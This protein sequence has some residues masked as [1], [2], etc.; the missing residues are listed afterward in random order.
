MR[1]FRIILSLILVFA[2]LLSSIPSVYAGKYLDSY[3]YMDDIFKYDVGPFASSGENAVDENDALGQMITF[4]D[5]I[6]IIAKDDFQKR[7]SLVTMTEFSAIMSRVKLGVNNALEDVYSKE[8]NIDDRNVT[9]Y[10]AYSYIIDALGYKYKLNG[11]DDPSKG[12]LVVASEIGLINENPE[13]VDAYITRGELVA[14]IRDALEIDVCI[15]YTT[16]YG[17]NYEVVEGKTLLNSVHNIHNVS[18][19]V[20]AIDGLSVYGGVDTRKGYIQ[21]DRKNFKFKGFK[22]SDYFGR[23]VEAYA[24]YDEISGEYTVFSIEYDKNDV[25]YEVDFKDITNI[26]HGEIQYNDKDGNEQA[27]PI[28]DIIRIIENGEVI[29]SFDDMCDYKNNDGKIVLTKSTKYGEVDTAIIYKYNYFMTSYNDARLKRIG[30]KFKQKYNGESYIQLD[31]KANISVTIDGA[32]SDWEMIKAGVAFRVMQ[33]PSTGYTELVV[34][35]QI[36]SGEVA[37]VDGDVIT[38]AEQEM[39]ISRDLLKYIEECSE[40]EEITGSDNIKFPGIGTNA[41]FYLVD[42]VLAGVMT[43]SDLMYGYLRTA[44]LGRSSIN[45]EL[46]LRIFGQNAVWYDAVVGEKLELDGT[47]NISRDRLI[48]AIK[49]N[50]D[51]LGSVV[52]FKVNGSGMLTLLDTIM[53]SDV[54]AATDD[55]IKFIKEF[56]GIAQWTSEWLGGE[57]TYSMTSDSVLFFVPEDDKDNEEKIT[58]MKN[59]QLNNAWGEPDFTMEIYN[60]N[61]FNQIELGLITDHT[62]ASSGSGGATFYVESV[63]RAILDKD[64]MIY[65]YKVTGKQLQP[66]TAIGSSTIKDAKFSIEEDILNKNVVDKNSPS[67]QPNLHM[68][69]GDLVSVNIKDG[70]IETW[71]MELKGS[72]IDESKLGYL[73]DGALYNGGSS[74]QMYFYG[75]IKRVSTDKDYALI[76]I[77]D[78]EVTVR[79]RCKLYVD[80]ARN[81]MTHL[82]M[83]EFHEG[84]VV[85]GYWSYGISNFLMKN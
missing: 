48:E 12:V 8:E 23:L 15:M 50:P 80:T 4:L 70:K 49:A 42:G 38:V 30:I 18:G 75:R 36:V 67:Y 60:C 6:G 14:L 47:K 83:D 5:T 34:S 63:S 10:D 73:A 85:F 46:T 61:D 45:P 25:T 27:Y 44:S 2:C 76:Q 39:R 32:V 37:A 78:L 31:D 79:V 11:Y 9:Y 71:N 68:E 54:E 57:Y 29:S 72:K 84:D 26:R 66:S 28:T 82:K 19:F 55:D 74:A 53:E 3:Q 41:A 56:V 51:I 20:N 64:E 69:V 33:C 81:K 24:T 58:I 7:D 59:S 1:K 21:I 16:N 13:A 40:N 43:E 52:R 17:Y 62:D 77:G 65:G 22:D 35:G